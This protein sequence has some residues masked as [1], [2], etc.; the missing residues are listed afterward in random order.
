M[1]DYMKPVCVCLCVVWCVCVYIGLESLNKLSSC[2]EK[3]VV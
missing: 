2:S 3:V 1:D